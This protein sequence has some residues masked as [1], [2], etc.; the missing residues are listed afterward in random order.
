M[1]VYKS[2]YEEKKRKWK[3]KG[4]MDEGRFVLVLREKEKEERAKARAEA[5]DALIEAICVFEVTLLKIIRKP[6]LMVCNL[7]NTRIGILEC[8]EK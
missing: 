7:L 8:E 3:V 2:I 6:L 1:F 4:L 5:C